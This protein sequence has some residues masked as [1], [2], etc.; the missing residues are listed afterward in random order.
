MDEWAQQQV[1]LIGRAVFGS[2]VEIPTTLWNHIVAD[3]ARVT[4]PPSRPAV[5]CLCGSTRFYQP[6]QEA[7]F[8][9]TLAGR[10]VLSVGFYAHAVAEAHGQGVGITPEQKAML[11]RLH[12][13]KIDL[14]DE[15]FVLTQ[16]CYIGEST[17]NEIKY[18]QRLGK[19]IRW[20]EP[21]A[22][23]VFDGMA[24]GCAAPRGDASA[25]RGSERRAYGMASH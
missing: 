14:A 25:D 23:E 15:V 8:R 13:R 16:Q 5:V 1:A 7:N 6:F 24:K 9:E 19:P 3:Y 10:I 2:T 18:A 17:F 21:A 4:A 20:W 12:L 11:D 22:E